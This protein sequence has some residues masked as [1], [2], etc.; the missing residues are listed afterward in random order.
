MREPAYE[1]VTLDRMITEQAMTP[2]RDERW[3]LD[4]SDEDRP[5]PTPRRRRCPE[6]G[7]IGGHTSV[8]CPGWRD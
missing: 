2:R 6:C 3:P 5:R 1:N 7:S 4:F 8:N